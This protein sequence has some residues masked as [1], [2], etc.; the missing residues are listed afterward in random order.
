M[1]KRRLNL[2]QEKV[3]IQAVYLWTQAVSIKPPGFM[4]KGRNMGI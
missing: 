4:S 1:S 2:E 3:F